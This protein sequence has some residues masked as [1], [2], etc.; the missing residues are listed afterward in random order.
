MSLCNLIS[1]I[2]FK[3]LCWKQRGSKLLSHALY[4][5]NL[6]AYDYPHETIQMQ[7]S[8][9]LSLPQPRKQPHE[10]H[11]R[12]CR[13]NYNMNQ[14][15]CRKLSQQVPHPGCKWSL[16]NP[17]SFICSLCCWDHS[18]QEQL[19]LRGCSRLGELC[20]GNCCLQGMGSAV[21][22]LCMLRDWLL[23]LGK[24]QAVAKCQKRVFR[25]HKN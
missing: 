14:H 9:V 1:R 4:G 16:T 10:L 19:R 22:V 7:S 13:N 24:N 8:P 21:C 20:C 6:P 12:N 17:Y 3:A 15:F 2:M 23:K 25:E 11:S 5:K 18:L